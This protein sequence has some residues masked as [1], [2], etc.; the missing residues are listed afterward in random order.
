M[1][2]SYDKREK[3]VM[4]LVQW[5]DDPDREDWTDKPFE[6]MTT[7]LEALYEFHKSNL[8]TSADPRLRD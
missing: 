8:D 7:D 1:G 4:Y 2:S 6:H 5:L 3:H